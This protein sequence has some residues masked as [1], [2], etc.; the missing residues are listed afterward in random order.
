[1]GWC[2]KHRKTGEFVRS[3]RP[4]LRAWAIGI[5]CLAVAA[6]ASSGPSMGGGVEFVKPAPGGFPI[7]DSTSSVTPTDLRIAPLDLLEIKVFGV[8]DMSGEYQV[9]PDGR[10]KFPLVGAVDAAGISI[11]DLSSR[12]EAR[13]GEKA[14]QNPDVNVRIKEAYARELT[15]EGAVRKPGLFPVKGELTLIQAVA[16]AE[17]PND[18]ANTNRVVVF[19][20][21]EGKRMAASFDLTKIRKGEAND[22][23]VYGNDVIVVDGSEMKENYREFLRS[24]PLLTIFALY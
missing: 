20:T 8:A 4:D 21:I 7:P 1:M 2:T 10:I 24:V 3:A 15:V 12:L 19:R 5:L 6:C 23:Q 14:L 17:G 13:L 22:P 9:D 16:M 18:T 11:F